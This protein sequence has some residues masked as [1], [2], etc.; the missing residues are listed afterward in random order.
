MQRRLR[1]AQRSTFNVQRPTLKDT[2]QRARNTTALLVEICFGMSARVVVTCG[3]SYEPIDEVRRITNFSTGQ[4]GALLSNRLVGAGFDVLCFRGSAAPRS[5]ALDPRVKHTPFSTND[6][7]LEKLTALEE[8]D[9]I[10]AVFHAA[11]LADFR[12]AH[13]ATERKL[14]SRSGPLTLTLIP[15]TK[16]IGKLRELFPSAWL[17]GWKYELDGSREDV[18]AKGRK[19]LADNDTDVCVVNGAAYGDGFGFQTRSGDFTHLHDKAVL[20]E[21]LAARLAF[22]SRLPFR[23]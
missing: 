13:T 20:C 21:F 19:Q 14:S 6:D 18:L 11:A 15:A 3:P 7:L 16:L 23:N 22:A 5:V 1:H 2:V 9:Q 8:R 10:A 17:V 12:V 4:L